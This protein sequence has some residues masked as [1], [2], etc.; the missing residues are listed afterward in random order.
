VS[1]AAR[2]EPGGDDD[3]RAFLER[4]RVE[5][6]YSPHTVAAYGRDLERLHR[7]AGKALRELTAAD[8]RRYAAQLHGRGLAPR[9]IARALSSVRAFYRHLERHRRIDSNPAADVRAPR[10]ERR[11]PGTLDTDQA[12]RLFS[13]PPRDAAERRDHAMAELLYGSGLRLSELV[14]LD[15]KDLDLE[16]GFVTVVGKGRKTRQVPLGRHSIAAVRAM[17]EDR[18]VATPDQPLLLGRGGR[19]MSPRTVQKRLKDLGRRL[20]AT[21]DLHPHRLR[22][23]FAS[24]LLES[25]GDLRAIQELLGHADI[26]T[27]Q[28]YT[29]LDFQRLATVYDQAH[30]RATG[31]A[32]ADSGSEDATS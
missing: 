31:N 9:S 27:T 24:H 26:A 32:S 3:L 30:P 29:H 20:L 15:L 12:A 25:S 22:H 5:K 10:G 19:R 14:G 18:E 6:Q 17:L 28:I 8:V 13:E 4:L 7:F 11:L 23:S 2:P 1:A 21:D 16:A